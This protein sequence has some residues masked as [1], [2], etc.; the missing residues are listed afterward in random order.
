M[1]KPL[2]EISLDT[3]RAA[4]SYVDSSERDVWVKMG[5]ALKSEFGEDAFDVFDQWSGESSN[6]KAADCK[7]VWR[8][9]KPNGGVGIGSLLYEAQ[10][11]G[12]DL[13]AATTHAQPLSEAERQQRAQERQQ[14][15]AQAAIDLANAQSKAAAEC[16]TQ[17]N[18]AKP[19]YDGKAW[20][21]TPYTIIKQ[22]TPYGARID[23]Q[24]L[25]VP[26]YERCAGKR[27]LISLQ[28]INADGSKRF[29]ANAKKQNGFMAMGQYDATQPILVCEGYATGCSL[30]E[31]TGLF[32]A[33]AFDAGNIAPVVQSMRE[34]LPTQVIVIC[35]DNDH[36]K[37]TVGNIGVLKAAQVCEE[38]DCLMVVTE[39]NDT[40]TQSTEAAA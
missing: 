11:G 14:R 31:S 13:K 30:Y 23:G 36:L 25:L 39:L 2:N 28:Y 24:T 6:Y 40:T 20:A 29:K 22:I 3:A 33:V 19:A 17:W 10:Q 35:A 12:F 15:E 8:S 18:A 7:A 37:P 1:P 4:L 21:S 32:V 9:I 26:V 16:L 27:E 38:R 5:Q 34:A